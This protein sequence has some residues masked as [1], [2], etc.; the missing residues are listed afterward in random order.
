MLFRFWSVGWRLKKEKDEAA[1]DT[2]DG[3]FAFVTEILFRKQRS[4]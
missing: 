3:N 2:S 1:A 4:S